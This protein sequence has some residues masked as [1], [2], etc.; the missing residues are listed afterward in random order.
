MFR[1]YYHDVFSRICSVNHPKLLLCPSVSELLIF[2]ALVY[3][4]VDAERC[5]GDATNNSRDYGSH[6]NCSKENISKGSFRIGSVDLSLL[7]K[8]IEG[9]L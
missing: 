8:E 2:F 4:R 6:F 3:L 7:Y 9:R 5:I 1:I